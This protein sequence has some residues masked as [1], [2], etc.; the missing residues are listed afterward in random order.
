MM[1]TSL[2]LQFFVLVRLL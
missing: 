1:E 2:L